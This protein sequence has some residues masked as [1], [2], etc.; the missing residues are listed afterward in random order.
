[1]WVLI[2]RDILD[3]YGPF[4]NEQAGH[5]YAKDFGITNYL[6]RKLRNTGLCM[7]YEGTKGETD[8]QQR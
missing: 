6:M 8:A 4:V 5:N 7:S 1:M 2:T 3:F